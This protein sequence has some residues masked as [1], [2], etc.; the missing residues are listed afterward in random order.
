VTRVDY[1]DSSYISYDYDADGNLTS[2]TDPVGTTTLV[3]DIY[4]RLTDEYLP[5]SRHNQYGY[6]DVGDLTSFTDAGGAVTY[7][8]DAADNLTGITEPGPKVTS[9][10]YDSNNER[11]TAT[12]PDGI[13]ECMDYDNSQRLADIYSQTA[14]CTTTPPP[15]R[16]TS[17][18]YSYLKSST[19]QD[20]QQSV[21]ELVSGLYSSTTVNYC[22]DGLD[23]LTRASTVSCTTSGTSGRQ[24]AYDA[25]GNLCAKNTGARINPFTCGSTGGS[26]TK[27][28]F[29]DANQLT[30]INGGSGFTYDRNGNLTV[31][32][33][34]SALSYNVRDQTTSITPT[35][36]SAVSFTYRGPTD[37]LR[38]SAGGTS[39]TESKLGLSAETT[40]STT[41]YYTREPGGALVSERTS[42]GNY[43]YLIDGLGSTAALANP[44]ATTL[45]NTYQ[46]DPY[47]DVVSSSG[48]VTNPWRYA[49]YY[50][51]T[52]TGLYKVGVRYYDP[53]LA[54]WTQRDVVDSPL[55]EHGWNRYDYVGDDP[56][57]ETD[58]S[59]ESVTHFLKRVAKHLGR[60]S[61]CGFPAAAACRLSN[62]E[63]LPIVCGVLVDAYVFIATR[64]EMIDA[65]PEPAETSGMNRCDPRPPISPAYALRGYR[66]RG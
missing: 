31:S 43:Y 33:S 1:S 12:F 18:T 39:F 46:Y 20:L 65:F 26:V 45:A 7:G 53:S 8:Y 35:G 47:G 59:G 64:G 44:T 60:P 41:T 34:F 21:T 54:R 63:V 10:T 15:A 5:G 17:F 48:T 36:A 50:Y 40:G 32:P 55:D 27:Y 38:E 13:Y 11:K 23:R 6:D 56:I 3:Y 61:S 16:L 52:S 25:N 57:N 66:K 4:N 30:G 28:S 2:M 51:D 62:P 37:A 19:D 14:A 42:S 58:P 9:F 49:G 24:Y 29:G 22:Y